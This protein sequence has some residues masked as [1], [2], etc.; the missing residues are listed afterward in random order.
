MEFASSAPGD[1]F[2]TQME[3]VKGLVTFVE[4]GQKKEFV[5]HVMLDM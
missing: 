3:S 2:S 1:G 5:K 4:H